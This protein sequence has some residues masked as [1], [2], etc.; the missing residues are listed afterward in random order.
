MLLLCMCIQEATDNSKRESVIPPTKMQGVKVNFR[1]RKLWFNSCSNVKPVAPESR[2][3]FVVA[4]NISHRSHIDDLINVDY[5]LSSLR[6]ILDEEELCQFMSKWKGKL[7]HKLMVLMLNQEKDWQRALALHDWMIEKGGYDPSI[8]AY[9][10]V[11]KRVLKARK[12]DLAE[13]LV[14]EMQ[15]KNVSPDNVTYSTFISYYTKAGK[16]ESAL[17][18]L[19]RMEEVKIHVDII[20]YSTLIELAIKKKDYLKAISLF[21]NLR[22]MKIHPDF[23]LFNRMIDV[24]CK[25]KLFRDARNLFNEMEKHD[26]DPTAVSYMTLLLAYVHNGKLS[27][28]LSVFLEMKSKGHRPN[29][30]ACNMMIRVFGQLDM[31]SEAEKLFHG[32]RETGM[33]RNTRTYNAMLKT[34][35]EADMLAEAKRLFYLMQKTEV[36][37]DVSTYNTMI[38]ICSKTLEYEKAMELFQQ[39]QEKGI[40]PIYVTFSSL[41]SLCGK[42]GKYEEAEHIFQ[43]AKSSRVKIDELLCRCMIVVYKR[44]GMLGHASRLSLQL[45][46]N[47][48]SLESFINAFTIAGKL[49]EAKWLFDRAISSGSVRDGCIY[50]AMIEIFSRNKKYVNVAG[51]YESMRQ[52]GFFP[53]KMTILKVLQAYGKLQLFEK[54]ESLYREM[55]GLKSDLPGE[56]HFHMMNLYANKGDLPAVITLFQKLDLYENI[57]KEDLYFTLAQIYENLGRHN[58]ASRIIN[59]I[60]TERIL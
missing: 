32:M 28:A 49:E 51:V 2:G 10:V 36:M 47:D 56:V 8:Y 15:N 16:I 30:K 5:L 46:S 55:Q 43:K 52:A 57:H 26:I 9:N 44:A 20:T 14:K 45:Q 11:L 60:E 39:M 24:F 38:K 4:D 53:S 7:P 18:W 34:Y 33:P 35:E 25:L 59:R 27:E 29:L 13:G 58:D 6:G 41:I 1:G 42:A 54:A 3:N 19:Q 31:V 12:W 17:K 22:T 23:I 48:L 50:D 37:M 40:Q 21:S